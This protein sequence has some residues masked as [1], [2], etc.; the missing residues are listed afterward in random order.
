[1]LVWV[2]SRPSITDQSRANPKQSAIAFK[3]QLKIV[4]FGN[5]YYPS[6]QVHFTAKYTSHYSTSTVDTKPTKKHGSPSEY[7]EGIGSNCEIIVTF[8][9]VWYLSKICNQTGSEGT[10][11][12]TKLRFDKKNFLKF[13]KPQI[14]LYFFQWAMCFHDLKALRNH[15]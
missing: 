13:C 12:P 11:K 1:M 9:S 14:S 6:V 7:A 2:F 8:V 3:T 5:H 15:L 4:L 10:K